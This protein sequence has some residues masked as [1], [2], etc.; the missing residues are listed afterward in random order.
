MR[1]LGY[2]PF[3]LLIAGGLFVAPVSPPY[4]SSD[5]YALQNRKLTPGAINFSIVADRSGGRDLVQGV[6]HNIC[7]ADFRTAPFRDA[8][9]H[10]RV[11]LAVCA[12]YGIAAKDCNGK[13]YELDDIVSIETGGRNVEANLWPE[14]IRQARIKDHRVEDELGG[15]RGLICQGKIGLRDAQQCQVRDWVECLQKVRRLEKQKK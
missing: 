7:A 11:K 8:T 12:K 9:K 3:V 5:G 1:F 15:P 10:A 14:P 13:N 4:R 2:V 6:E